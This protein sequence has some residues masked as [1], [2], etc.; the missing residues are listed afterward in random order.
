[1]LWLARP[2]RAVRCKD[3][4][5]VRL[6][7]V[8]QV[9]GLIQGEGEGL[10]LLSP[11]HINVLEARALVLAQVWAV[12]V[13]GLRDMRVGF[14]VDSQAVVGAMVTGAGVVGAA[15]VGA[16]VTGGWVMG[17]SVMGVMSVAKS[18]PARLWQKMV[19]IQSDVT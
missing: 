15:V 10:L 12:E 19:G 7:G 2:T 17:A 14:L 1:M 5:D 9:A 13:L 4:S 16:M 6:K 18:V 11:G 3:V 8:I